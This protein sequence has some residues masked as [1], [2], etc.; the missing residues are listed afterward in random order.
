MRSIEVADKLK[1]RFPG[2]GSEF[3]EGVEV[4]LVA[5]LMGLGH[6]EITRRV[7]LTTV[8]QL[9][10][11]SEKLGYYISQEVRNADHAEVTFLSL[12]GRSRLRLVHSQ[13]AGREAVG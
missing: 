6:P 8:E 2:R 7:A 13:P 3:D 11:L 5:A 4:G 12:R 10:A 1:V 9:T